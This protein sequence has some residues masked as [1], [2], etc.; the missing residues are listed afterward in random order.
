MKKSGPIYAIQLQARPGADGIRALRAMLKVLWRQHQLRC[1]EAHEV[2][3][4]V[5]RTN[6]TASTGAAPPSSPNT[7]ERA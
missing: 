5:D 2:K 1:L 4:G 3:D 7:P 6:E